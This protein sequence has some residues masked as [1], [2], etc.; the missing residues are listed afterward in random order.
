ME[1]IH[2]QEA[3]FIQLVQKFPAFYKTRMLINVFIKAL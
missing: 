2:S 1:H 3:I